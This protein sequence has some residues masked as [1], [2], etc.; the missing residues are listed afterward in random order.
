MVGVSDVETDGPLPLPLGS[1]FGV[2]DS[3]LVWVTTGASGPRWYADYPARVAAWQHQLEYYVNDFASFPVHFSYGWER[4]YEEGTALL[5]SLDEINHGSNS[6]NLYYSFGLWQAS[7][8]VA[9]LTCRYE[10]ERV[11]GE[12]TEE[13]VPGTASDEAMSLFGW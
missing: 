3:D 1:R 6:L 10:L 11:P 12:L 2:S 5:E 8:R 13:D 4:F 9:F 7:H